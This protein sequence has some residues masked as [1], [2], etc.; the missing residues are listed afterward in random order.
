MKQSRHIPKLPLITAFIVIGMNFLVF[1]VSG[2]IFFED[3]AN[4]TV[5]DVYDLMNTTNPAD[6]DNPILF[7]YDPECGSCIPAHEYL[8]TYIEGHPGTEIE[9]MN[10]LNNQGE[11]A[12]LNDLLFAYHREWM[13]I[14]VIFIGPVALEGT[15]EIINGFE[16]VYLWYTGKTPA[17]RNI[18]DSLLLILGFR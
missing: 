13:N 3:G 15:D 2:T 10:L 7:F 16:E 8:T 4:R 18:W 12:R 5:A 14:P 17:T 9:M 11:E 6:Y 1:P